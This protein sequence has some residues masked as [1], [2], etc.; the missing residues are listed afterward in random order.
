MYRAIAWKATH[1]GL[2]LA[3]E[4][5]VASIGARA[6]FMLEGGRVEI[7][8]HDVRTAIRTPEMDKAATTVARHPAVRKV[9]VAAQ[10]RLGDAGGGGIGGRG[11]GTGGFSGADIQGHFRAAPGRQRPRPAA[12]PP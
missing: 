5:A 12:G 3:D 8:G 1:D 7:D 9:L 6:H 10:R 2:D 4:A 11:I